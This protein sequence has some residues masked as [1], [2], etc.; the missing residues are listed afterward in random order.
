MNWCGSAGTDLFP[1]DNMYDSISRIYSTGGLDPVKSTDKGKKDERVKSNS[2]AAR[3]VPDMR[4]SI[5]ISEEGRNALKT[6]GSEGR[7]EVPEEVKSQINDSWYSAGI[8]LAFESE[9]KV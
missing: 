8:A 3:L 6:M 4:D 2:P 7:V 9:D 5:E 1:G